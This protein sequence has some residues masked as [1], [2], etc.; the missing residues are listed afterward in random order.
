MR[1]RSGTHGYIAPEIHKQ[2]NIIIGPEIDI[3]G[4]GIILYELSVG[5]KPQ[6][7]PKGDRYVYREKRS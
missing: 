5:Y 1:E 7:V 4:F 6:Q 3:W 2:K